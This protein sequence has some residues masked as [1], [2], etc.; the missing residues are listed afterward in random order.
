MVPPKFSEIRHF[1]G[2]VTGLIR[3]I[4]TTRHPTTAGQPDRRS[5]EVRIGSSQDKDAGY[6]P[7]E[8]AFCMSVA[9]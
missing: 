1:P 2:A 8:I 5:A 3:F 4:L 6:V 7:A 9:R